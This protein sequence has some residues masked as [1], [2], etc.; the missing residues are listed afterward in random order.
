[1]LGQRP[2]TRA[3]R[4]DGPETGVLSGR[5]D[6]HLAAH[7]QAEP[8][9]ACRVDVLPPAQ[10]AHGRFEVVV[11]APAE[12]VEVSVALTLP[13]TVEEQHSVAVPDQHASLARGA[14]APG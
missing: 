3:L 5:L 13:S 14:R 9:D 1:V 2:R 4:D 8:P 7:R 10:E 6:H 12:C 11:A